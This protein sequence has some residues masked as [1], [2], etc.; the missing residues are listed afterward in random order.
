MEKKSM[1][2]VK[3]ENLVL[4]A[5]RL[6]AKKNGDYASAFHLLEKAKKSGNAEAIYALATWYLHGRYVRKSKRKALKLLKEAVSMNHAS[7]C[8]D[9]A[10]CYEAGEGVRKS[11]KMALKMYLKGALLGEKQCLYE[12][13][14]CYYHAVGTSADRS[15]A[16][17]WL[18]RARELGIEE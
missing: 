9:L 12:V 18:D 15:I 7:A 5:R 6:S 14:R 8:Y 4:E 10:V 17:I 3:A 13:G 11:E 1:H 2:A 16:R